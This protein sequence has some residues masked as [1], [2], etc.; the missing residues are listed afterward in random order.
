MYVATDQRG[1]L[2]CSAFGNPP[3]EIFWTKDGKSLESG[4][5]I[6][7]S[8]NKQ[9]VRVISELSISQASKQHEGEYII[10][11]TNEHGVCSKIIR[12]GSKYYSTYN[13]NSQQSSLYVFVLLPVLAKPKFNS[14][15]QSIILFKSEKIKEPHII[16]CSAMGNPLPEIKWFKEGNILSPDEHIAILCDVSA[17][18]SSCSS[19]LT[20]KYSL[21]SQMVGGY[22]V[23]LSNEAGTETYPFIRLVNF[24][25]IFCHI[26]KFNT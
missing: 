1:V 4:S 11:A 5:D 2:E 3:P 6:E 16:R 12:L 26:F 18:K 25:K 17:D 21:S 19:T 15:P 14:K 9:Q 7:I 22:E 10:K 13:Y 23:K 8:I 20:M 24:G